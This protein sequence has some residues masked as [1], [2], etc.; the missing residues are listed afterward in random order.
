MYGV[1]LNEFSG[2]IKAVQFYFS[3]A[4]KERSIDKV[5]VF[6]GFEISTAMQ[7]EGSSKV[8]ATYGYCQNCFSKNQ[9]AVF[10]DTLSNYKNQ[11]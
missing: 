11:F 7:Y 8:L 5:L 10:L 9:E 4:K 3:V 2:S 1:N 6:I